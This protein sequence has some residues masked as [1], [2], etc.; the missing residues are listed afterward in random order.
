MNKRKLSVLT[1]ALYFLA[2]S[3][4]ALIGASIMYLV[5]MYGV[6]IDKIVLFSS[7][8][9]LGRMIVVPFMGKFVEK[10]GAKPMLIGS[11]IAIILFLFGFPTFTVYA[12]GLVFAFLGGAGMTIQDTAGPVM[13][14]SISDGNSYSGNLSIGQALFSIGGFAAPFIVGTIVGF[15]GSFLIAYYLIGIVPI[16]M[17]AILLTDRNQITGK[18]AGGE[19]SVVQPLFSKNMILTF[20]GIVL[21]VLTYDAGGGILGLY[22]TAFGKSIGLADSASNYMQSVYQ[23]GGVIGSFAFAYILKKVSVKKMILV[24]LAV[25]ALSMTA[26]VLFGTPTTFFIVYALVGF[27]SRPVF[28]MMVAIATR[29]GYKHVSV[30]GSILGLTSGAIGVI[31]PIWTGGLVGKYGPQIAIFGYIAFIAVSFLAALV[32]NATTTEEAPEEENLNVHS[33]IA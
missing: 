23:L 28:S 12:A 31:N 20:A 17:L 4:S 6:S 26:G 1:Y 29:V 11:L 32:V 7:S 16:I 19:K 13:I 22:T 25:S 33:E 14:G 30:V 15:G 2:G 8:Y 5:A 3:E 21:L 27:F 9:A 18:V 10:V 24:N